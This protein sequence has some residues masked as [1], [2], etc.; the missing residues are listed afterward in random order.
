M[1]YV[2]TFRSG[3][4]VAS[5]PLPVA[6]AAVA[7]AAIGRPAG[8][9]RI[10]SVTL[11]AV[12]LP[13]FVVRARMLGK[14]PAQARRDGGASLAVPTPSPRIPRERV[15]VVVREGANVEV[16]RADAQLRV[17]SME[18][19]IAGCQLE[20]LEDERSAVGRHRPTAVHPKRA[21]AAP[22][23]G[24]A[25]QPAVSRPVDLL[26]EPL[27]R[28]PGY[29]AKPKPRAVHRANCGATVVDTP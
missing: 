10:V 25:P 3:N 19:Q 16:V 2:P 4:P 24:A 7:L 22:R 21:V 23:R 28:R 26:P 15:A 11:G 14:V 29:S 18:N 6:R 17:T 5:V 12:G 1:T 9:R 8:V 20:A 27:G 13:G